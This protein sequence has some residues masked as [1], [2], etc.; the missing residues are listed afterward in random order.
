MNAITVAGGF[1]KAAGLVRAAKPIVSIVGGMAA[2]EIV[3]GFFKRIAPNVVGESELQ[4]VMTKLGCF[5]I[6]VAV[7]QTVSSAM[8]SEMAG[9]AVMLDSTAHALENAKVKIKEADDGG[10]SD[11]PETVVSDAE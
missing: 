8:E 10:A 2:S 1:N 3:T 5:A 4:K 9:V 6:G 7:S 11:E